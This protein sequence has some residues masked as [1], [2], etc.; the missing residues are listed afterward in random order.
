MILSKHWVRSFVVW[1]FSF[2]GCLNESFANLYEEGLAE[3]RAASPEIIVRSKLIP[4]LQSKK[5][6]SYY[7]VTPR[8]WASGKTIL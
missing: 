4:T 6:A 8:T 1:G 7:V 5:N 2:A 3:L